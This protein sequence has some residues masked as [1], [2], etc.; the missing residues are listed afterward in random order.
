MS[1]VF[2][3]ISDCL[4]PRRT[5]SMADW[6]RM[7]FYSHIGQ[8]F[9]EQQSP[10]V[11]APQGPCW[12]VDSI[13]FR[14]IWLQWAA[15]MFKTNFG[16]GML[17]RSMDQ[18]PEETMF[19]TPDE[20]NCKS[21]FGRFWK[22][23]EH[24]PRLRNQAPL[25]VRQ[26]K[27]QIK[28]KRS[29]CHGAWPRG[30]SRLADKSIR[31]GLG[32]EIDKWFDESTS[33]EGDPIARFRKRAAE[34][35]D[36]K[37]VL[38]STPS[39]TGRSSVESGRLQSTN[40][41][42]HVP[43]PHCFKFQTIEFGDGSGPGMIH[44]DK[45]ENGN[46]SRDLARR[47]AHYV[48][49]HCESRIDDIH[50]PWMMNHGVW[51][52]AGCAVDHEKA[53][54]ARNLPPDDMS[55]LIGTPLN[56]GSDYGSQISVFYAL[57]HGW[58]DIV[59]DFL[60]KC[61]K[62]KQLQQW[63]NEDKGETW[64]PRRS[65]STPEKVGERLA[66]TSERGVVPPG[67]RFLTVTIDRQA[68]DGG[69]VKY[70]VL[71]HGEQERSALIDYGFGSTLA[72]IWEPVVR[73]QYKRADGRAAMTPILSAADSGWDTKATYDFCN[74]RKGIFACK[75]EGDMGGKPYRLGEIERGENEGQLLFGVNTDYWETELQARLEERLPSEPGSLV[76]FKDA[77]KDIDF[78]IEICNGTLADKIDNRGNAKLLWVKKDENVPN[79]FRD[80]IRYGLALGQL[81]VESGDVLTEQPP[82][83]PVEEQRKP[84]SFVRPPAVESGSGGWIRRRSS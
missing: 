49:L 59:D 57:F 82:A 17:M 75:G 20:T 51:V 63:V 14:T 24:C 66:G 83:I 2:S 26:S 22:M 41:R 39:I 84:Q 61:K 5:E 6:L 29:V 62:P 25:S 80:A 36:R 48:C 78:L 1:F 13:Q 56:W 40:H 52:P 70:I 37:I 12:A 9:S 7:Y 54:D 31:V 43:C 42:Y 46:T 28:L 38:E 58:G 71:A 10:W 72:D 79:D 53:M 55:W 60:G 15:R 3:V 18:R 68:A 35:P 77:A 50:R 47:T 19:A 65:K 74:S 32:N 45:D 33:T 73:R 16:L 34:Y 4:K 44:Y 8:A 21:V 23:I 76:L 81:V 11:T 27:T 64:A 30:K 69:F 67:M